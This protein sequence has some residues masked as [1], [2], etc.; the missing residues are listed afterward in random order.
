[1]ESAI[2]TFFYEIVD[3]FNSFQIVLLNKKGSQFFLAKIVEN[4]NRYRPISESEATINSKNSNYYANPSI[5]ISSEDIVKANCGRNC[6]VVISVF[7]REKPG[8][9]V[10]F[11]IEVTQH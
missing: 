11:G 6:L 3:E 8:T 7:S 10:E 4:P 5:Q 9:D 2:K 1:M